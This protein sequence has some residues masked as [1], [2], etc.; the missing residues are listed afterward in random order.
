MSTEII[1]SESAIWI[2]TLL[3]SLPDNNQLGRQKEREYEIL[4][5]G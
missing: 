2:S 4:L 5:Y 1:D 3:E